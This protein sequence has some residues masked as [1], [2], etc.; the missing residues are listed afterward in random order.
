[1]LRFLSCLIILCCL[2]PAH[3]ALARQ[4]EVYWRTDG[5][6]AMTKPQAVAQGFLKAVRAEAAELTPGLE[7][8]RRAYLDAYLQEAAPAFV[9]SYVERG[10]TPVALGNKLDMEVTVNSQALAKRLADLG[11]FATDTARK[12][13]VLV[14]LG[15]MPS[16]AFQELAMLQGLSNLHFVYN[17]NATAAPGQYPM[18]GE[19]MADNATPRLYL[20]HGQEAWNARLEFP[21]PEGAPVVSAAREPALADLWPKLWGPY[22]HEDTPVAAPGDAVLLTMEG[23]FA[24]DGVEAFDRQMRSWDEDV[25]DARLKDILLRPTGISATWRVTV[26][27]IEGFKAR[28]NAFAYGRNLS[29]SLAA[30]AE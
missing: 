4:V 22:F 13:K 6:A 21:G 16:G 20:G 25:A 24:A 5:E 29:Y 10:V 30:L 9:L 7:A 3:V 23:W 2:A 8:T 28:L 1:M 12:H 27:N 15:G 11:L 26:K 18:P 14:E 19:A 17:A